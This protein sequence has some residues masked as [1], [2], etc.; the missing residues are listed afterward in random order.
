MRRTK[1]EIKFILFSVCSV[2]LI[3]IISEFIWYHSN[4]KEENTEEIV[5]T[6]AV[7]EPET[8]TLEYKVDDNLDSE[9]AKY[10][11][12]LDT[13]EIYSAGN[14]YKVNILDNSGNTCMKYFIP[15]VFK[16]DDELLNNFNISIK[17]N[18]QN[19]K[20]ANIENI[21]KV[22]VLSFE[23]DEA[24]SDS[25]KV[26]LNLNDNNI[27]NKYD[28][29]RE[30][31]IREPRLDLIGIA[32]Y[33][34]F[35][36][37]HITK[38][39]NDSFVMPS[40]VYYDDTDEIDGKTVYCRTI[41][42]VFRGYG[43][44]YLGLNLIKDMEYILRNKEN[45]NEKEGI[46]LYNSTDD[47]NINNSYIVELDDGLKIETAFKGNEEVAFK[48]IKEIPDNSEENLEYYKECIDNFLDMNDIILRISYVDY[49][50]K[51]D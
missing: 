38:I 26:V 23:T 48:V 5:D 4:T 2:I 1:N 39:S 29:T 20:E 17:I 30:Y 18:E 51:I 50:L 19:Y 24:C 21:G 42:L 34:C 22:K 37:E 10:L 43:S 7:E 14:N 11:S 12:L 13:L 44:E 33:Q 32:Q 28:I 27:G 47:L 41:N 15:V 40:I 8:E 31:I 6:R 25:F 9:I 36:N 3:A 46:T 16:G 49:K 35:E 45:Q